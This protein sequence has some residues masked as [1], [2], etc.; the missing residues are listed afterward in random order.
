MCLFCSCCFNT[1]VSCTSLCHDVFCYIEGSV[2]T[3]FPLNL[4]IYHHVVLCWLVLNHDLVFH[5]DLNP[6]QPSDDVSMPHWI[7]ADMLSSV[8]MHYYSVR[9]FGWE[10]TSL[11]LHCY[12]LKLVRKNMADYSHGTL[13][14]TLWLAEIVGWWASWNPPVALWCIVLYGDRLC[15]DRGMT[16]RWCQTWPWWKPWRS[17]L[18]VSGSQVRGSAFLF[19]FPLM[20]WSQDHR[21]E[22]VHFCLCFHWCHGLRITEYRILYT[23]H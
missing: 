22:G 21:S 16:T 19:V 6:I 13:I 3:S 1:L 14:V 5:D 18:M 4:S 10:S 8:N 23:S 9:K 20:P 17:L 15:S 2:L 11:A 7:V 12:A